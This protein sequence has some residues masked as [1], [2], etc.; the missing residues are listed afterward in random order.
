MQTTCLFPVRLEGNGIYGVVMY[1]SCWLSCFV[2]CNIELSHAGLQPIGQMR[3]RARYYFILY[4]WDIVLYEIFIYSCKC[5]LL[6][7]NSKHVTGQHCWLLHV[8]WRHI[9]RRNA[10]KAG[11][12]FDYRLV[13]RFVTS[14]VTGASFDNGYIVLHLFGNNHANI[15]DW[16]Q[17][18]VNYFKLI[19]WDQRLLNYLK[20]LCL[21]P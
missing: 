16:N 21:P 2:C 9:F 5:L 8:N 7:L 20:L 12:I 1:V 17:P 19:D 15:I 13:T 11:D 18:L 6:C 14:D 10:K 3:L 4:V